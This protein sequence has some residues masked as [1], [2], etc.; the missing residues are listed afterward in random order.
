MI[1]E[2][3]WKENNEFISRSLHK[4]EIEIKIVGSELNEKFNRT[5]VFASKIN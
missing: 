4:E 2:L 1:I 3:K 5:I